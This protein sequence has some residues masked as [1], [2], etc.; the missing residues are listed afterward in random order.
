MTNPILVTGGTGDLGRE[1]VRRLVA[2]GRPVRI[3]SRRS[4]PADEPNE[5]AR[6]DL[7]T[8]D[9]LVEAVTGVSAIV[10]CASTLGR[11]DE[12]VTRN[13]VEAAKRAGGPHLVYISIVGIDVIRFFYYDEK[14][15][16]EKVIEESGL[17][18]TVLR[19]TQFHELVAR[20]SSAQR[21]LPVTIV[22]SGFRF[23]PVSTGD[24][25]D[26]LV[27]LVSGPPSGRV[28]DMGGPEVRSA[29]DLAEA[30]QRSAGRRKP[31]VSLWL[32]GKAARAFRAGGNLTPE[33]AT[34]AGTFEEFLSSRV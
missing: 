33:N 18:W 25:A 17:P 7:K 31:I 14:L 34:G 9:G 3:M 27:A 6:C 8:G 5:W 15:A 11:G 1:V 23:Q 19:A 22:P 26:R 10:H 13:L 24:V 4:R 2:G 16:C 29:R 12:Q 30:Y 32:P 20:M 28:P 21:R